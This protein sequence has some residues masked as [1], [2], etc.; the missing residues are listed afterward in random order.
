MIRRRYN[1]EEYTL[2]E[3][4]TEMLL[5]G[6]AYS[7]MSV[8]SISGRHVFTN[9]STSDGMIWW[10]LATLYPFKSTALISL[11][12]KLR[13]GIMN[14]GTD[15]IRITT[16]SVTGAGSRAIIMSPS[17]GN[18]AL[19]ISGDGAAKS[20]DSGVAIDT[21]DH[22]LD[23][24]IYQQRIEFAVDG[25]S[26]SGVDLDDPIPSTY[27]GLRL[28]MRSDDTAKKFSIYWLDWGIYE[29]DIFESSGDQFLL[30]GVGAPNATAELFNRSS[31]TADFSLSAD[32]SGNFDF[33]SVDA[34]TYL[35]SIRDSDLLYS[36]SFDKTI[37]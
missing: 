16:S 10:E 6:V 28:L 14:N 25:G 13:C 3:T 31:H 21:S 20:I 36:I 23:I 5:D 15:P 26:V 24:R 1:A 8:G 19:T 37:T 4:L 27:P 22:I 17:G 7:P 32:A 18:F 29:N 34:G 2:G 11:R 30:D 35:V 33:S 12:L 9:G